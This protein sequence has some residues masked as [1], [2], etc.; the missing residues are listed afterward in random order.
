LVLAPHPWIEYR[1]RN[2]YRTNKESSGTIVFIPKT[3]PGLDYIDEHNSLNNYMNIMLDLPDKFHPIYFCFGYHDIQKGILHSVVDL[4][5]YNVVTVGHPNYRS[6]VDNFYKL[7]TS[8]KYSICNDIG[9]QVPLLVELGIPVSIIGKRI[10]MKNTNKYNEQLPIGAIPETISEYHQKVIDVF[11]GLNG[12][13]S[14]EQKIICDELIGLNIS[15]K[16]L[17][18]IKPL[19]RKDL[20]RIYRSRLSL[21]K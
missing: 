17:I 7:V 16:N 13:I 5:K 12:N 6:F 9:T 8:F 11:N 18:G 14:L 3:I 19:L 21:G 4:K 2:G 20:F 15:N 1:K 10:L